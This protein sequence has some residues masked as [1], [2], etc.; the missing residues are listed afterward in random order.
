VSNVQLPAGFD[1][2]NFD[3]T[4]LT[5]VSFDG[6]DVV[7]ATIK[8]GNNVLYSNSLIYQEFVCSFVHDN[9][10]LSRVHWG[11]KRIDND[12]A[13]VQ[14]TEVRAFLA[15]NF[16]EPGVIISKKTR[17]IPVLVKN[18]VELAVPVSLS[19]HDKFLS[20]SFVTL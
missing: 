7:R 15:D 5:G 2:L 20:Y 18:D 6:L 12:E 10:D 13:E 14:S 8:F 16:N 11:I 17:D 1:L 4:E 9:S 3:K 19:H